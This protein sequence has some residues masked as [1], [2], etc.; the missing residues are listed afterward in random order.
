MIIMQENNLPKISLVTPSFNQAH[1]L[2]ATIQSVVSQHY[3]RLE[4]III[5]GG[6]SD[7]SIEVIKKYE[8]QLHFWCSE[9]DNG[10]YDAINKGFAISTGEIMAWLN[11]DDLYYPWT[12]RT[13]ASIFSALPQI[14]W[15]TT[16]TPCVWDWQGFCL[17]TYYTP[18]YSLEAFLEGRYVPW[19]SQTIGGIQ[20]ESTFWR[21]SLWEKAGGY[22]S[23]NIPLAG[24]F[25]LWTRFYRHAELYGV[26]SLLGGFR[27]QHAQK[28][29][30]QK[31]YVQEAQDVL[32]RFRTQ[33]AWTPNRK[34]QFVL[35]L[36]LHKIPRLWGY[37]WPFYRYSGKKV[38]RRQATTPEG[39]WDIEAYYFYH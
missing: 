9:F 38:V 35:G 25:E 33:V 11:S 36:K 37:C 32:E 4:Y 27:H 5:D 6:S 1:F 26:S 21:R 3:P 29:V 14:E 30:N 16:R 31:Q 23:T 15:L 28:S 7:G 13:V 8:N 19:T 39:F 20:Q 34:R 10:L 22:V 24:D 18:G 17:R 2:E 12:L